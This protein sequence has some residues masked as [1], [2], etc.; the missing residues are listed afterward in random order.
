[1]CVHFAE[2]EDL[3][4][5]VSFHQQHRQFTVSEV[6]RKFETNVGKQEQSC[7]FET[8]L[9]MYHSKG[10]LLARL[11]TEKDPIPET[12]NTILNKHEHLLHC[13]HRKH[14]QVSQ[15]MLLSRTHAE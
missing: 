10:S 6:W 15:S 3:H 12:D 13:F 7:S 1:M 14:M 4:A 2:R 8:G 11:K 9:L 5:S